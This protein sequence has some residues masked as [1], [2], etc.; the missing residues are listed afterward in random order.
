MKTPWF[1]N[2]IKVYPWWP[3]SSISQG[4]SFR[5]CNNP[6][7]LR[8]KQNRCRRVILVERAPRRLIIEQIFCRCLSDFSDLCAEIE[9]VW[10]A[11]R[12]FNFMHSWQQRCQNNQFFRFSSIKYWFDIIFGNV[13]KRPNNK[14]LKSHI[15]G[16]LSKENRVFIYTKEVFYCRL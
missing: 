13:Y 3:K 15:I 6:G 14:L 9:T 11:R 5:I 4:Y 1:K 16:H 12:E 2:H 8:R 7:T 10:F